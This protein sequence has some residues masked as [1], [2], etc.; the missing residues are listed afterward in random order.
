MFRRSI[1]TP[2]Q[3]GD[4]IGLARLRTAL[5][6]VALRRGK[7]VA[8]NKLV[9][10]KVELRAIPFPAGAG[11]ELYE[12]LYSTFRAAMH[13]VLG[14][15]EDFVLQQYSSVLELLLRMRQACNSARLVPVHRADAALQA[16]GELQRRDLSIP[17]TAEEGQ[18]LFK[19][20]T[21]ALEGAET[22]FSECAVCLEELSEDAAVILRN[23]SHVF[24]HQCISKVAD[25]T[26]KC[27]MW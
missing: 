6:H 13:A 20:L 8:N 18:K 26:Q 1:T 14:Q 4:D 3:N 9:N 19:R 7:A 17:L 15:G 22:E 16:W 11:K 27:P 5:A 23:C 12:A 2:I 21:A 24:C 25:T 10:K